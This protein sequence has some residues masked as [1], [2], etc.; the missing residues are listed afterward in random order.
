VNE[1]ELCLFYVVRATRSY[2]DLE[3]EVTECATLEA[4]IQEMVTYGDSYV[5]DDVVVIRGEV[6]DLEQHRETF[7][8]LHAEKKAA[9]DARRAAQQERDDREAYERLKQ[10]FGG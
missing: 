4:A 7:K 2:D 8:R 9:D 6:V 10:K 1:Q 3:V 5:D